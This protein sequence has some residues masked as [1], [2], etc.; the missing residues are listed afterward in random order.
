MEIKYRNVNKTFKRLKV[1]GLALIAIVFLTLAAGFVYEYTSY[2]NVTS[3][4]PPDGEMID[5]GNRELHVNIKGEKTNLPPVVIETGFGSWSYDWSNI[6]KELS[7]HTEVITYDRAGYGWSD[8]HPNGYRIDT[9]IDDLSKVVD[10]S[11][12]DTP[13]ILVGH[14]LGGI[15][16]RLFADKYPEKVSGLILVDARNEFLTEKETTFNDF[17]Y[18]GQ[19]LTVIRILSQ[20]GFARLFG[21]G[22]ISDII[23]DYLSL[24]KYVNVQYDTPFLRTLNQE[25]K[26]ER[27]LDKLV[28][29]TQH[30]DDKPL[31]IITPSDIDKEIQSYA[32]ELGYSEQEASD[33]DQNWKDSQK[34]LTNISN[35]SELILVPNSGHNMMFDQPNVIIEAILKMAD[36]L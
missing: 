7:K 21:E 3:N 8:P 35:N 23:P 28:A 30:L 34:K 15:Y 36:D 33:I 4:F 22:M 12:V 13:V 29:D 5:V 26:Q 20:F 27:T 1:L 32:I 24:E 19:D 25:S 6:Q 31:T 10:Y 16:S 14:S 17:Y 2:K 9:T 11:N 18:E